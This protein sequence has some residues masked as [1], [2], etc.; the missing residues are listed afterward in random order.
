MSSTVE[1]SSPR[2]LVAGHAEIASGLVSAVQRITGRGD[3]LLVLDAPCLSVADTEVA[4]RERLDAHG[5]QVVFTDLQA[6]SFTMAARRALRGRPGSVLVAGANLPMLL[7][8]VLADVTLAPIEAAR[9]AAAK[10]REAILVA[11][12]S[13]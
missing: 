1:S 4:V 5:L 2:A 11:E 9:A 13:A 12:G 6:G 10:G 7:D 8:F 3:V